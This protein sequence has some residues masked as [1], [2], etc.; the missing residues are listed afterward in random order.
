MGK[1]VEI[2]KVQLEY[3]IWKHLCISLFLLAVSPL[4]LGVS[5]LDPEQSARVLEIY[6]ALIGIILFVPVFLPEQNRDLWYVVKARY[7]SMFSVYLTRLVISFV[8]T[9]VLIGIYMAV[10]RAGNCGMETGKYYFGTLAEAAAFGGL[11]VFAC[12]VSDNLIAG[13]MIPLVYYAAALGAGTKYLGMFY[14]FGMLTDYR[15]KYWLL[16]AGIILMMSGIIFFRR[17]R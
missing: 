17:K 7:T 11:G 1:Y 2:A 12:S 15:T 13:Y 8:I 4:F 3:N 6:V 10:M 5:N 14:P 9:A 16:A